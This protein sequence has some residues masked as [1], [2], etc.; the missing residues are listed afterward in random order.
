MRHYAYLPLALFFIIISM[1][2]KTCATSITD[3]QDI[4]DW[5]GVTFKESVLTILPD[6]YTGLN[7]EEWDKGPSIPLKW[8][9]L[10][11]TEAPQLFTNLIKPNDGTDAAVQPFLNEITGSMTIS[12]SL[13]AGEPSEPSAYGTRQDVSTPAGSGLLSRIVPVPEPGT[14]LLF[15]TGLLGLASLRLRRKG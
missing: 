14:M 10:R 1:A 4:I 9:P 5:F 12:G 7:L 2:S 15:G 11:N 6:Q 8:L 13:A 3:L